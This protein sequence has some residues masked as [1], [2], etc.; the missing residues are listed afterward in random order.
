M[1]HNP[2]TSGHNKTFQ[3]HLVLE[4]SVF[5]ILFKKK[6]N[7]QYI[8]YLNSKTDKSTGLALEDLSFNALVGWIG[9]ELGHLVDFTQKSNWKVIKTGSYYFSKKK[10][11]NY[12][13]SIDLI[14]INHG[15]GYALYEGMQFVYENE[16]MSD[17]YRENLM[18]NYDFNKQ[19]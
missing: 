15:L 1:K 18:D 2:Y 7:R 9:H 16:N 4:V 5:D 19:Q 3:H 14:T 6:E 10:K 17:D 12:E 13:R 11:A 8:V